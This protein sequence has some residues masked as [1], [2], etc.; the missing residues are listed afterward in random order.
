MSLSS[1]KIKHGNLGNFIFQK[2]FLD[3][4]ILTSI[5]YSLH[6]I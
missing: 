1:M 5:P 6:F 2:L 3:K 4:R